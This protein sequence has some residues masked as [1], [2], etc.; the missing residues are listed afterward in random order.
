MYLHKI[1][2]K[3]LKNTLEKFAQGHEKYLIPEIGYKNKDSAFIC[4]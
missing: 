4:Q 1:K 2:V 3:W